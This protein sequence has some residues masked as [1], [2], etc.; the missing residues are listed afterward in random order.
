MWG[1]LYVVIELYTGTLPWAHLRGIQNLDKVRDIKLEYRDERLVQELPAE[2]LRILE[3]IQSLKWAD[4]PNYRLIH[5]LLN[6]RIF[7]ATISRP[8]DPRSDTSSN[9]ISSSMCDFQ[10]FHRIISGH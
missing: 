5:H 4:R 3:H 7:P 2:F 9:D 8:S 6:V 1:F 10:T